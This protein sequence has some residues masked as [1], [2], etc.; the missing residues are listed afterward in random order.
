[1]ANAVIL[2]DLNRK[3]FKWQWQFLS[4]FNG[5]WAGGGIGQHW[6]DFLHTDAGFSIFQPNWNLLSKWQKPLRETLDGC[7]VCP[8]EL[9]RDLSLT[10]RQ[11]QMLGLDIGVAARP[12]IATGSQWPRLDESRELECGLGWTS[13]CVR[14]PVTILG[15]MYPERGISQV[16]FQRGA[17]S[18]SQHL[19]ALCCQLPTDS[20]FIFGVELRKRP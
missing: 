19:T 2:P 11:L 15:N 4:Q 17:W 13:E 10:S 5:D 1:M 3:C 12:G 18:L 9:G 20:H 14:I 8:A 16:A 6:V 7:C